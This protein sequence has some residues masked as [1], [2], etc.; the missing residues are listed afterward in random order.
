MTA[1]VGILNRRG[2]AIAADSAVTRH[3]GFKGEKITKN[4]NKML[5][6]SNVVPI[7]IMLTGN[8]D[9]LHVQWDIVIRRYRQER[10]NIEHATVKDCAQDFFDYIASKDIFFDL[11]IVKQFIL[12]VI[13]RTYE[14][15]VQ[16]MPRNLDIRD[17]HGKLKKAKSF[18]TS[19]ENQCRKYQKVFLKNGICS[20]FENYTFDDFKKF[21]STTDMVEQFAMK[22]GYDE[23]DCF[24]FSKGMPLN[25]LHGVMEEFLRT[26]YIRLIERHSRGG[27]LAELVFTGFGP[28]EK[29]PSLLSAITYEGFDNHVNYYF[30]KEVHIDDKHPV[31]ICPFAQDD[32]TN[33]ILQGIHEK[34][35]L[36]LFMSFPILIADDN[37]AECTPDLD[38]QPEDYEDSIEEI[39]VGMDDQNFMPE[40]ELMEVQDEDLKKQ[41]NSALQVHKKQNQRQWEKALE[42]YNLEAMAALAESLIDLTGFQR[43]LNF[44]PEGVGG[45]VDVAVISRNDGFTWLSRKSWYHHKDTNGQYG[46]L[47]V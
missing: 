4:G 22:Y 3:R 36:N 41:V 7:S 21:L 43:I 9:F 44:D 16:A 31:A 23:E 30:R 40:W 29:Y 45:P 1:V 18:A 37:V 6:L 10:G 42:S 13:S 47:G 8:G 46:R 34:Y 33:S 25:L 5:R 2:A 39:D 28:E 26:V 24:V 32:I 12:S 19:F 20:Q 15:V 35:E 14:D 27:R 11:A 17:E 38:S